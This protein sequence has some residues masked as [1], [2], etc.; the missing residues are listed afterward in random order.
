MFPTCIFEC[1]SIKF[2]GR[3]IVAI[4]RRHDLRDDNTFRI[5]SGGTD[6]SFGADERNRQQ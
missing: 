3:Q 2:D 4:M 6:E 5:R 1:F